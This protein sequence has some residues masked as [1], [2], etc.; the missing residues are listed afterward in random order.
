M[1]QTHESVRSV[2][3]LARHSWIL[4]VAIGILG[5]LFTSVTASGQ[6]PEAETFQKITGMS[7]DQF[8]SDFPR[9]A[10]YLTIILQSE[11]QFQI[12]FISLMMV[13]T[14]VPFRRGEQWAWYALWVFPLSSSVLALR[15]FLV[16]GMGWTIILVFV[17]ISLLGLLLPYRVFFPKNRS[18]R[19]YA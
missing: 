13:V 2:G 10:T 14:V 17:A 12:S 4:F 16:G 15:V 11:A 18:R 19:T 7:V 3:R 8:Q 6:P 1:I 5:L 9:I